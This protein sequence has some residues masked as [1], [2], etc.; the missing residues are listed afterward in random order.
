MAGWFGVQFR[1]FYAW[2]TWG[3]AKN[4]VVYEVDLDNARAKGILAGLS[5][6]K[7]Q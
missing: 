5:P 3:L 2:L 4:A 7:T 1:E 6:T